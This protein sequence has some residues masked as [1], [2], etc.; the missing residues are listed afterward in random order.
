MYACLYVPDPSDAVRAA[1]RACAEHFSPL[2][3]ES[4]PG[5]IVFDARGLGR[6]HAD[7]HAL[8]QAIARDAATIAGARVCVAPDPH[9]AMTAARGRVG[10]TVVQSGEEAAALAP[11]K[12]DLLSPSEEL[13][14]TLA[15]WGIGILGQLAALPQHGISERLGAEGLA[16]W[17]MA[18]GSLSRPLVPESEPVSFSAR[19]ELEHPLELLEPLS[20]LLAR[21]LNDVCSRLAAH[22]LAANEIRVVLRLETGS[23]FERS[24]RLPF[25]SR[26]AQAFLKLLQ[27]DLSAHPPSAP[28]LAVCVAAEPAEPRRVQTGLFVPVAPDAEKLELTL[29]RLGAIVGAENVGSPELPDSHRPGAFRMMK[30]IV[31]DSAAPTFNNTRQQLAIRLCRPPLPA[32]VITEHGRPRRLMARDIRGDITAFAGPW[33]TSGEWWRPDFWARDEWDVE[34]AGGGLYRIYR[35]ATATPEWFV[36]GNYD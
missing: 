13:A 24:I 11:L 31:N 7:G 1:L 2:I 4:A 29:A 16:L 34:L 9:V 19:F 27:L 15:A 36:E 23:D 33:R 26:D 30:F 20:F 12:I 8:A 28:I 22:G 35:T 21:L 18:R 10:I 14:E 6:L 5:L 32:Q 17:R 3:E 25:A